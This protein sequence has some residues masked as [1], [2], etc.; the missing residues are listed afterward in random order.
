MALK[1]LNK[2]N[3]KLK[4]LY[5]KD[6]VLN[7]ELWRMLCDVLIQPYFDYACPAWYPDLTEKMKIKI[8]IMQNK[9]IRFFL[10]LDK[11]HHIS[12]EGFES[13]NWLCNS[14]GF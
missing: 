14:K 8:Q 13:T 9:C 2:I 1:I 10:R 5:R 11:M 7:P 3:D 12:E 4:F 6:R